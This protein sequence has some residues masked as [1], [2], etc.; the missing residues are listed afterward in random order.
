MTTILVVLMLNIPDYK[1]GMT[2]FGQV[3]PQMIW[4]I[5][6]TSVGFYQKSY[7]VS[8]LL[9]CIVC[10]TFKTRFENNHVRGHKQ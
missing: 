9:Y 2:L 6:L 10:N 8:M 7:I 4:N 1:I 3:L 5:A